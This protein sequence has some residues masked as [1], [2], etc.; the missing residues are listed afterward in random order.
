MA[1][2]T[3]WNASGVASRY[4]LELKMLQSNI[5]YQVS[6]L[7]E[8]CQVRHASRTQIDYS[9]FWF[10]SYGGIPFQKL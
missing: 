7:D 9:I 10:F 4:R 6:I 3:V 1:D 5:A 8:I 2:S